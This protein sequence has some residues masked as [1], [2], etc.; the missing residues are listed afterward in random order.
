MYRYHCLNPISQVGLK[1]FNQEYE[2]TEIKK[3]KSEEEAS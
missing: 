1:E 3:E 2:K